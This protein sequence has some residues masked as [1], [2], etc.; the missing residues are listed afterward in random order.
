MKIIM[1][2]RLQFLVLFLA[3]FP[4]ILLPAQ[5]PTPSMEM[6]GLWVTGFRT[7]VLGDTVAENRLLAYALEND[8]NTLVCTNIFQILTGD[9]SSF[10]PEMD[11][12]RSFIQKAHLTYG[13]S[14]ISGNVGSA[15][16]AEKI[17][18]YNGCPEV[19][20]AER[21]DMIT[22]EC[23]FYNSG[24]NGSC[25]D[26]DSYL[27]SLQTIRTLCDATFGSDP[28]T[29]LL[30]EV[31]I[32]GSGSTGGVLTLSSASEM[33]SIASLADH[34]LLTYYRT[35]P[36]SSSGN[37]FNWTIGRLEWLAG[38]SADPTRILLLLKSRPTD[39]NNMYDYLLDYPGSHFEALRGPWHA[40]VEGRAFDPGLTP[41]YL[42]R[43]ADNTYPWL[44]GIEVAGFTWFEHLTNLSI[45]DSLDSG[46]KSEEPVNESKYYGGRV[47]GDIV[48]RSRESLEKPT[49][50][51]FIDLLG[52]EIARVEGDRIEASSLPAGLYF[53]VVRMKGRV[54]HIR[55]LHSM[56]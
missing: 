42:E 23:E 20:E 14:I 7:T 38:S 15:E 26:F 39:G 46:V 40:W 32:G 9:C 4:A 5:T 25:P 2:Y 21:F 17:A 41:G 52:R 28:T 36:S 48:V 8:L 29:P 22:Y 50:L 13:I 33:G 24:T 51:A 45:V 1:T 55:Y 43:Y 49:A 30:C 34:I 11:D 12:L 37:F 27:T 19:E 53:V 18:L 44:E 35:D 47:G 10:T 54:Q 3:L 6:R 56:R 31:Y 16:T